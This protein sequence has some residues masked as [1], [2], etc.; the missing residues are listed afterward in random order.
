MVYVKKT[1]PFEAGIICSQ[2]ASLG[3]NF[4]A[5]QAPT[6]D[7]TFKKAVNSEFA[8][9]VDFMNMVHA[10]AQFSE[11]NNIT[12]AL[13]KAM[14]YTIS[15]VD[16]I[17]SV[18]DRDPACA[19]AVRDRQAAGYKVTM[20]SDALM[21][22]V[23]YNVEYKSGNKLTGEAKLDIL[24]NLAVKLHLDYTTATQYNVSGK[25]L[26]WGII[27][28]AYLAHLSL[29]NGQGYIPIKPEIEELHVLPKK[30]AAPIEDHAD[31]M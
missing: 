31:V 23:T 7:S 2:K 14:I 4:E 3:K 12:V 6:Q 25:S 13:N 17:N 22:D 30:A 18:K 21:A 26:Y 19:Q 29:I 27:D 10:D 16:V 11:I 24:Q 9:G 28:D 15:D 20:I 8:L 5:I 1:S